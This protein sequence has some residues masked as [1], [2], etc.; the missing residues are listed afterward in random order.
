MYGRE[1][2]CNRCPCSPS[3]TTY[4]FILHVTRGVHEAQEAF[5]S[6]VFDHMNNLLGSPRAGAS[7]ASY[8][9]RANNLRATARK[10][11]LTTSESTTGSKKL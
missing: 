7:A 5:A 1:R 2:G 9:A 4:E 3:L 10:Q 6:P 11:Q 8:K